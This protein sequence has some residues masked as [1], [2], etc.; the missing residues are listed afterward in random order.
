MPEVNSLCGA[1]ANRGPRWEHPDVSAPDLTSEMMDLFQDSGA[2][3]NTTILLGAGASTTSGLPD[4]DE[5]AMRLLVRSGSVKEQD[6]ARLLVSRQDP[7][8]VAEAACAA[9][10]EHWERHLRNA[11]YAETDELEPSPLHLAA[12]GHFLGGK[13]GETQL[14]TLNFDTLLENAFSADSG[15]AATPRIDGTRS[16]NGFDV[17]HLHGVVT[18]LAATGVVL[19][20]TDFNTLMGAS[21]AW[22]LDYLRSAIGRGALVIAG[23]SYRDPDLRQWLHLALRDRPENHAAVVLLAREGFGVSKEEFHELKDAL[24]AQWEA[25]G[26]RPVLLQDFSDAAQIIRELRHLRDSNYTPPQERARELWESHAS[27]FAE[28]QRIYAD[29]LH[30]DAKLISE[31][32]DDE[33][34]NLTLWLADGRGKLAR[35]ASQDRY[36]RTLGDIRLVDSGHDSPWIA[37]RALGVETLLFQDLNERGTQRWQSVLASPI[38]VPHPRW[39]TFAS[40]VL[41]VGLPEQAKAYLPNATL[42][43]EALSRVAD[44]WSSRLSTNAFGTP[45]E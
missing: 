23:T 28:L 12:V 17:H 20:L 36:Q 31:A 38:P 5:L 37:G 35:W 4:W 40:A 13:P 32:L 42:W 10:G 18:P 6:A 26:M 43:S 3:K 11:L 22:Q 21:D 27:R 8:L 41:S 9:S 34:I 14:V 16:D 33:E 44:A 1:L 25:V 19:T 24:V 2:E 30:S 7:L 15:N 39:P 45:S 29:Q